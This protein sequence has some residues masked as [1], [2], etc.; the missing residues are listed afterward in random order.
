MHIYWASAN[1]MKEV[2]VIVILGSANFSAYQQIK[3]STESQC[4]KII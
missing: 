2:S 1:R 3:I 4:K